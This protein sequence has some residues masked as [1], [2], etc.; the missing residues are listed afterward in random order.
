[1]VK[2]IALK[3]LLLFKLFLYP[4]QMLLQIK[5]TSI[6]Y[7]K[8][9]MSFKLQLNHFHLQ[10]SNKQQVNLSFPKYNYF[11][12]VIPLIYIQLHSLHLTNANQDMYQMEAMVV[13]LKVIR[14]HANLDMNLIMTVIVFQLITNYHAE[15]VMNQMETV[16]VFLLMIKCVQLDTNQTE[17]ETVLVKVLIENLAS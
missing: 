17:Q 2:V 7:K 10:Q 16:T 4:I 8:K 13:S 15:L 1:M 9:L 3:C 11:K 5:K 6:L 12:W 14:F